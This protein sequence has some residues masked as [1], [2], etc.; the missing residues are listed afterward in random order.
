PLWQVSFLDAANGIT[1]VSNVDVNSNDISPE[2]G[3][4]S[5]PVIDPATGT[6]YVVAKTKEAQPPSCTTGCTFNYFYRLHALD[7]TTGA[8]KFGGPVVITATVNGNGYDNVNGVI[9]FA[10]LTH[11]QRP[12]LMLLNGAVFIGFGS[13]GDN[14]GYHGWILAYDAATLQQTGVFNVTP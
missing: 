14:P 1:T 6:L 4:T 3:I 11:L 5:T 2:I 12:A 10:P 8:E 7:V 13:H 9:T